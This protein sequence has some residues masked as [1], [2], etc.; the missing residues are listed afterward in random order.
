MEWPLRLGPRHCGQSWD[1]ALAATNRHST[2]ETTVRQ[3]LRVSI[4]RSLLIRADLTA[5]PVSAQGA[6]DTLR[7]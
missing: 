4:N 3:S 7:L 5:D 1:Q 2:T 6:A